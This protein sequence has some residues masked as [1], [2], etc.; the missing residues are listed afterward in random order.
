MWSYESRNAPFVDVFRRTASRAGYD[1]RIIAPEEEPLAYGR[2]KQVY[3]HMSVNPEGFELASYRRWF[4]IAARVAPDDIFIFADSDLVVQ[5]GF[6][7]LPAELR[8]PTAVVASI[9]A[10]ND[11]LEQQI[12]AGFSLWTGRRLRDFCDFLIARYETGTDGLAALRD[13]M[14][15][16]GN[17]RACISDMALLYLWINE[18]G[19][20]FV[21]SNRVIEGQYIDHV[22]FMPGCLGTQFRMTFGRKSLTFRDDGFWLKSLDGAPVRPVS[23]HLG[24]RYKILAGAIETGNSPGLALKSAYLVAGRTALGVARRLGIKA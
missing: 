13:Q 23:L 14:I 17:P 5:T 20:P 8:D 9:G 10:T 11:V 21:N 7:D 24:G 22:F 18:A 12:N 16:A 3:R 1:V 6:A 4:E 19:V 15:A 2:F